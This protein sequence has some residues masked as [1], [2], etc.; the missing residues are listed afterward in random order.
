MPQEIDRRTNLALV[1]LALSLHGGDLLALPP[2]LASHGPLWGVLLLAPLLHTPPLWFLAHEALHRNLH[3]RPGINDLLGRLLC[4]LFGAPFG[5]LR[6]GHLMHHRFN[7]AR[8][9]RPDLYDPGRT[10]RVRAAAGYYLGLCG[11]FYLLEVLSGPLTLLPGGLL[12]RF[13]ERAHGRGGPEEAGILAALGRWLA[14][15]ANLRSWRLDGAAACCFW[16]ACLWAYRDH[17]LA[18]L[19]FFLGRAFVVSTANN[20]PHYGT[21]P[22]DR[23]AALNLTLPGPVARL[24]LDFNRHRLHHRLPLLPWSQLARAHRESGEGYDTSWMRAFWR[25]FRGPIPYPAASRGVSRREAG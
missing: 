17:S 9:D 23:L 6:F 24:F 19:F 1:F 11:G 22:G 4:A 12:R 18:L 20:L 3:P 8:I 7:G 14:Q 2:L 13:I 10:G 21:D 16:V 15:P 5:P 25:Q